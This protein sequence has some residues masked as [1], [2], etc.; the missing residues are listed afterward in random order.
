MKVAK[1]TPVLFCSLLIKE[2]YKNVRPTVKIP[3]EN[4]RCLN[5]SKYDKYENDQ[6]KTSTNNI[7]N[8]LKLNS[9][10]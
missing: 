6:T 1:K 8:T 9:L 5:K 3:K 10:G 7:S 2:H 4:C